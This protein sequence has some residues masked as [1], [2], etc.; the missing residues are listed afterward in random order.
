[1]AGARDRL[2]AQAHGRD[3]GKPMLWDI[4]N[5]CA[6]QG[7]CDFLIAR[8]SRFGASAEWRLCDEVCRGASYW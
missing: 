1:M 6:R 7:Y 2:P 4:M 8:G 5:I 3:G